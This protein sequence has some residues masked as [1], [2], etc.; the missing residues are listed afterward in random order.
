MYFPLQA[1]AMQEW[2][3]SAGC[4]QDVSPCVSW[5]SAAVV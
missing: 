1:L 3:P 5:T 4:W 2:Q